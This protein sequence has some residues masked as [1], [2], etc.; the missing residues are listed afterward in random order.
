MIF[1]LEVT[2]SESIINL[3]LLLAKNLLEILNESVL[4]PA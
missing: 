2:K 3:K 1:N 4:T